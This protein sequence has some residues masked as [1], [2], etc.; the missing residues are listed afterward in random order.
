MSVCFVWPC[1]KSCNKSL[2]PNIRD[3]RKCL[4]VS[5]KKPGSGK[6]PHLWAF[7]SCSLNARPLIALILIRLVYRAAKWVFRCGNRWQLCTPNIIGF[8]GR[9]PRRAGDIT[10]RRRHY[11][12]RFSSS[13]PVLFYVFWGEHVQGRFLRLYR[14]R[15]NSE[16]F[17]FFIASLV[18]K[19]FTL[20]SYCTLNSRLN[21]S[22][23]SKFA[24]LFFLFRCKRQTWL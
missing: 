1:F 12:E 17:I 18:Y 11:V 4:N 20:T 13:N 2:S 6:P 10:N 19:V 5:L 9:Y 15:V 24:G 21:N 23:C 7:L 8:V 14:M 3:N 16:S 22:K